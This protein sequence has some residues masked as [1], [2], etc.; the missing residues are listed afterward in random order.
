MKPIIQL[1]KIEKENL[2]ELQKAY[3]EAV[4][5][6]LIRNAKRNLIEIQFNDIYHYSG[7]NK[8]VIYKILRN[9]LEYHAQLKVQITNANQSIREMKS[10]KESLG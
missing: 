1:T 3:L 2:L 7:M 8:S 10:K 9:S 4:I 6:D 5:E